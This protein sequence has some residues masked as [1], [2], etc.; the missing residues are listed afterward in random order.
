MYDYAHHMDNH[1]TALKTIYKSASGDL[2][3][4]QFHQKIHD[5]I[6]YIVATPELS[7]ALLDESRKLANENKKVKKDPVLSQ[8][9]KDELMARNKQ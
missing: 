3:D 8:Q 1:I 7:S 5:Y 6:A 9:S 2:T 4:L